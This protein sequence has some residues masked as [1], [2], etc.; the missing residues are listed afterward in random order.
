MNF[1]LYDNGLMIWP[2]L[3]SRGMRLEVAVIPLIGTNPDGGADW[4]VVRLKHFGRR[5]KVHC[6]NELFW[7]ERKGTPLDQAVER[8]EQLWQKK[9]R[10]GWAKEASCNPSTSR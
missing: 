7:N 9:R 6:S 4:A 3:F 2:E 5:G 10:Q 1:V 8:A